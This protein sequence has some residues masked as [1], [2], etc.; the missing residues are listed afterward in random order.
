M[1]GDQPEHNHPAAAEEVEGE[2]GALV[3]AKPI[4]D[5]PPSTG[6]TKGVNAPT[7][8]GPVTL[9][10]SSYPSGATASKGCSLPT[11]PIRHVVRQVMPIKPHCNPFAWPQL[12]STWA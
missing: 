10:G 4:E 6:P 1:D 8:L 7:A 5:V 12:C 2:K 9:V 3:L 11:P